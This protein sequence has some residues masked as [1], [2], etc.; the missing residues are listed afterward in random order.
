MGQPD[1][2]SGT[3]DI[4]E[5][6][7][8]HEHRH[9]RWLMLWQQRRV[10]ASVLTGM[11]LLCGAVWFVMRPSDSATAQARETPATTARSSSGPTTETRNAGMRATA[12][13]SSATGGTAAEGVVATVTVHVAG[14]V[15]RPGVITITS[16]KRVIDAVEITGGATGEADLD[17]VNLAAALSDGAQIYIPR[18]GEA[19]VGAASGGAATPSAQSTQPINLNTATVAQLETLPGIGPSLATAIVQEREQHGA[20]KSVQDLRRVSGL[21][22]KRIADLQS[23]VRV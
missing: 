13:P 19:G 2:T 4:P 7:F 23:R 10:R 22:D 20:F 1:H 3:S 12:T 8:W 5:R 18:R 16:N 6:P 17:R 9:E 14:A 11:A 15:K 21:G